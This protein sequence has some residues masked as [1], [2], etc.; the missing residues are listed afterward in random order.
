MRPRVPGAIKEEYEDLYERL[1]VAARVRGEVGRA[2]T[3][4]FRHLQP[5]YLKDM[6]F[7]LP[8][9]KLLPTVATGNVTGEIDQIRTMC[10]RLKR[11]MPSLIE[12]NDA[13]VRELGLLADAAAKEGKP[14]YRDLARHLT[15]FLERE[16]HIFYPASVL[17]GE[18]IGV[19]TDLEGMREVRSR[20]VTLR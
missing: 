17:I 19:K 18:Y 13:L 4:A 5:H 8:P 15:R 20:L 16:K 2:A 7:A 1:N 14:E 11:Q 3:A 6:E 9:L 10:D 12:E